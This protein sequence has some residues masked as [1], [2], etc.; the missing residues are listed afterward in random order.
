M[1]PF[2]IIFLYRQT[3]NKGRDDTKDESQQYTV[4]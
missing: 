3:E 1:G 4:G 2:Q